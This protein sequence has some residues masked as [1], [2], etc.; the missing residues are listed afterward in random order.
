MD[1]ATLNNRKRE[2]TQCQ[3][4]GSCVPF[5]ADGHSRAPSAEITS[6]E[7]M[8]NHEMR[9]LS[10]DERSRVYEDLNAVPTI[11][12]ETPEL[13][14]QSILGL[15]VCLNDLP[16]EGKTPFLKA[17]KANPALI[18]DSNF[19]LLFLRA[20]SFDCEKAAKRIVAYFDFKQELFGD[21]LLTE[22]IT[23][24]HL[25]SQSRKIICTMGST[26]LLPV[27]DAAGRGVLFA[28]EKEHRRSFPDENV[29]LIIGRALFYY[30]MAIIE[31]DIETQK[32]G[33]VYIGYGI[34]F[35]PMLDAK[36]T[37]VWN[38][39]ARLNSTIPVRL[40]SFMYCYD[41]PLLTPIMNLLIAGLPKSSRCRFQ[42]TLG[43]ELE[44]R[45]AM[46]ARGIPV[47]H[48]PYDL[49]SD[50]TVE[51]NNRKFFNKWIKVRKEIEKHP[52]HAYRYKIK[53]LRLYDVVV[54][55][56]K[57]YQDHPGNQKFRE[58]ARERIE[59][60]RSLSQKTKDG[61]ERRR[62][63]IKRLKREFIE[64]FLAEIMGTTHSMRFVKKVDD[65]IWE[66]AT[67]E[68][69]MNKI[70]FFFNRTGSEMLQKMK[71]QTKPPPPRAK[72]RQ[73]DKEARE[74]HRKKKAR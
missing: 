68:D 66:E 53:L 24:R 35:Q 74:E 20:D 13:V 49:R 27:R 50:G 45:H 67:R 62:E 34:G 63:T 71:S 69:A 26:Q 47:T 70:L 56:G 64:N 54:G 33:I 16:A 61:V 10:V 41:R 40:T 28:M 36:E 21:E 1:A 52:R 55:T 32:H 9:A 31:D 37:D 6:T 51:L 12:E 23:L 30:F 11:A 17:H 3:C 65:G 48:L 25:D 18:A 59:E 44:C 5:A 22:R 4:N 8:L 14:H 73:T 15:H 43:S 38:V 57:S 19:C 60:Y 39:A 72:E 42:P 7:R 29:K 58:L 46:M 2:S